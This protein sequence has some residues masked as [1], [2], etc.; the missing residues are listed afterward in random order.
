MT[1]GPYLNAWLNN[2]TGIL[3]GTW[4]QHWD[5]HHQG[6]HRH[7]LYQRPPVP[8]SRRSR[9]AGRF[10]DAD[11]DGADLAQDHRHAIG[12]HLQCGGIN[13]T[14]IT[15]LALELQPEQ[16]RKF[17][18]STLYDY[19]TKADWESW[20]AAACNDQTLSAD[21]VAALYTYANTTDAG[22]AFPDL[23]D[24]TASWTEAR[25]LMGGVS[26][27]LTLTLPPGK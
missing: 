18:S 7:R 2:S 4:P 12:V 25:P 16:I 5:R 22:R 27:P 11:A 17:G 9:A 21:T 26:A 8:D 24:P 14:Q 23:Y 20:T 19:I 10:A 13:L 6:D 3:P 15:P 1:G